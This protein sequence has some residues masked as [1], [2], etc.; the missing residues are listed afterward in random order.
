MFNQRKLDYYS[1]ALILLRRLFN[2]VLVQ[3]KVPVL[4]MCCYHR[5]GRGLPVDSYFLRGLG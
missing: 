2:H 1:C 4:Q 3:L 5:Y